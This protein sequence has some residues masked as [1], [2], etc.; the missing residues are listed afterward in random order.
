MRGWFVDLIFTYP[1]NKKKKAFTKEN[2]FTFIN[3]KKR[4]AERLN[5]IKIRSLKQKSPLLFDE[6]RT[7]N[8][9]IYPYK[10]RFTSE[11]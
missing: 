2:T 1:V 3:I 8:L 9:D 10:L 7:F 5:V 4:I 6:Q 11:K